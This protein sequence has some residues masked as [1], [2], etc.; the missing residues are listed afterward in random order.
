MGFDWPLDRILDPKFY[1]FPLF[2][3][4]LVPDQSSFSKNS[5]LVTFLE[6]LP[7]MLDFEHKPP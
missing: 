4:S 5:C 3:R 2:F 6:E 7:R 1:N